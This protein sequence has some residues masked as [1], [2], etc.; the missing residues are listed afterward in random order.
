MFDLAISG[1]NICT[2]EGMREGVVLVHKGIIVDILPNLPAAAISTEIDIGELVLMPGII[3]PHVHI[4]EPGRT[5]WE[6]FETATRS[7]AAGGITTLVEMPLNAD[8]VTIT[9]DAFDKKAAAAEG[10]LHVNCGFWGGVVPANTPELEKLISKG[11]LGFKAFLTHSGI[12]EFPNVTGSDLHQSIPIIARH[13][14][15]LLVHAELTTNVQPPPVNNPQSYKSYLLSRPRQWE[16][17]AIALMIR[18]CEQYQCRVH[19]VHLSSAGSIEQIKQARQKGL[20]VTVETAQHYLY[21]NAEE[22]P[23]AQT[24]FKCAPPIREKENNEQLWQAL[25]E[26][27]IDFV[28]TDHSPAPPAMKEI[29]SGNLMKA[30]GGIASLQLALPVLWTAARKRNIPVTRMAQWLCEKPALLPGL[31][32]SKG[33]IA[34]GF[35]ADFVVWDPNKQFRVTAEA[36]HHK[37]KITPYMNQELYGVVEQTWLAG[38]LIFER[39]RFP[40]LNK[41]KIITP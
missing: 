15:P 19:I 30:W 24:A 22:I 39:G 17:D 41:G 20:P 27:T 12:D 25:Q 16:D 11:V 23:D 28:A 13:H 1:R 40:V 18:L 14:L 6:G 33:R 34:K 21:F 37:H 10:Q 26:D 35:D 29:S 38:Q 9:A 32:K 36:L 2:P 8:P 7:A 31:Q 4:N 3:D 5:D